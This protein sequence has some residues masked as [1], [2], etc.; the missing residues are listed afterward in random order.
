[1]KKF[2]NNWQN[3]SLALG[4]LIGAYAFLFVEEI[5]Q[6]LLL[7][8]I[9]VLFLHFFEEFGFP[10]GFPLMGMKVLMNSKEKDSTKW[11]CNNLNSMFGN[12]G[13]LFLIYILAVLLP[14]IKILTLAAMLFSFAELFMHLLLFN[15]KLKTFYNPGMVTGVFMLTPIAIYYFANVYDGNLFVWYDYIFAV[16]WFA[17]V[18]WF[19]F[20]SPLYWGLGKLKGYKLSK[21]SAY[22]LQNF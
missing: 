13:F 21:Q 4:I 6:N 14:E 16:A 8:S 17:V 18:F 11:N 20:R 2:V 19:S 22:G 3:I 9:A 5:T 7:L 1:M 12:W 15:V 10:G